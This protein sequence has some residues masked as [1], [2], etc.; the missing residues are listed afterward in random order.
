MES[1]YSPPFGS[2]RE[3]PLPVTSFPSPEFI[4]PPPPA[5]SQTAPGLL[6][7]GAEPTL[8]RMKLNSAAVIAAVPRTEMLPMA[9][10]TRCQGTPVPPRSECSAY[11]ACRGPLAPAAVAMRPYV[12]T[13]PTG[14]RRTMA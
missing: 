13:R 2:E 11:P 5:S 3:G 14:I 10:T 7:A 9:F 12:D 8:L 1:R 4:L 6:P